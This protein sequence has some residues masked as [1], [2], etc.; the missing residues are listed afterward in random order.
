MEIITEC[1]KYLHEGLVSIVTKDVPN[2]LR[3]RSDYASAVF[4]VV[5]AAKA[6]IFN[7][8]TLALITSVAFA[9]LGIIS[10]MSALL[11]GACFFFG[12]RVADESFKAALPDSIRAILPNICTE[13]L[14]TPRAL[15]QYENI[16]VFYKY[17]LPTENRRYKL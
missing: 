16:V 10:P 1:S 11:L 17:Q 4:L 8:C 14:S 13:V 5:Q 3:S 12:R 2:D 15:L 6:N 7:I 9:V